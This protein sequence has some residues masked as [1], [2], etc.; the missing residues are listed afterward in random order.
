[1]DAARQFRDV[2]GCFTTGVCVAA[3]DH[4]AGVHGVTINSFS[5][6]SLDPMQVLFCPRKPGRFAGFL[7]LAERF[8][9]NV[10]RDEQRALSIFFA[11]A[12]KEGVSP[13]FRFVRDSGAP[14]LEGS[15]ASIICRKSA[16][17]DGGDHWL[18]IGDVITLRLG[19][20][21]HVPLVVYKG[22]YQ[23]LQTEGTAPAVEDV[24]DEPPTVYYHG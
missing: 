20:V 5:A 15:L 18:V 17:H 13:P 2:L 11:G 14:R 6:L 8:S 4:D 3:V 19:V 9:L 23:R 16:V 7:A 21:P 10:L 24:Q 12:W 1:M 22:K